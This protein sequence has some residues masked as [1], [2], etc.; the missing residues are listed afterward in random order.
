MRP[1]TADFLH[2]QS[3]AALDATYADLLALA[4]QG[5]PGA[6]E[7]LRETIELRARLTGDTARQVEQQKEVDSL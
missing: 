2:Q 5:T 6:K 3:I 1:E 4:R 7:R